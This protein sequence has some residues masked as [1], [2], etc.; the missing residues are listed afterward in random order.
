MVNSPTADGVYPMG[1]VLN[2]TFR[3]SL[4]Q[5]SSNHSPNV[6]FP[7]KTSNIPKKHPISPEPAVSHGFPRFFMG[8]W[9]LHN[10][11]TTSRRRH[12]PDEPPGPPDTVTFI[13]LV[14]SAPSARMFTSTSL[15]SWVYNGCIYIYMHVCIFYVYI[16]IHTF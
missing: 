6:F 12:H 2:P 5:L 15:D 8:F 3:T 16:Y 9:S 4:N 13:S 11:V 1:S 14:P 7:N 10:D